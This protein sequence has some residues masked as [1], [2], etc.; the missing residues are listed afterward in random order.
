MQND[1]KSTIKDESF[2][3]Y[4]KPL[5][6]T[7]LNESIL[8]SITKDISPKTGLKRPVFKS[9]TTKSCKSSSETRE[10]N[11]VSSRGKDNIS[12]NYFQQALGKK[13]TTG[14]SYYRRTHSSKG[15]PRNNSQGK[16]SNSVLEKLK[17]NR[18]NWQSNY[19]VTILI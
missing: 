6:V 17:N 14:I 9:K 4:G 11:V 18:L 15:T 2:D 13:L 10:R 5:R 7:L 12:T 1:S 16:D 19:K 8:S 3:I